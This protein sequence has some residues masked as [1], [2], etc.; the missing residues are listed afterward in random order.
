MNTV[1][2]PHVF[3]DQGVHVVLHASGTCTACTLYHKLKSFI[4]LLDSAV[5]VQAGVVLT[6]EGTVV[7]SSQVGGKEPSVEVVS[8]DFNAWI[9]HVVAEDSSLDLALVELPQ[10]GQVWNLAEV[11]QGPPPPVGTEVFL[12]GYPIGLGWCVMH[13]EITGITRVNDVDMIET[14]ATY[15]PGNSGGALVDVD[16]RLLGIMSSIPGGDD[17]RQ[18]SLARPAKTALGYLETLKPN[19]FG[20]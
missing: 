18:I 8:G 7:T 5:S 4:V 19:P 9:G 1:Q 11:H 15:L 14:D 17:A 6:T 16:G 20:L 2:N 13:G 3:D 10:L 12:V